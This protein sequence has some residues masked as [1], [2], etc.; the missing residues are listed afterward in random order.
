[1]KRFWQDASEA[2]CD[3]HSRGGFCCAIILKNE[4]YSIVISVS[5]CSKQHTCARLETGSSMH[6]DTLGHS[7]RAIQHFFSNFLFLK[8]MSVHKVSRSSSHRHALL[9]D[10]MNSLRNCGSQ[11]TRSTETPRSRSN[12]IQ[13]SMTWIS[14]PSPIRDFGK[15]LDRVRTHAASAAA[16]SPAARQLLVGTFL[17]FDKWSPARCP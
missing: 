15:L 8:R 16:R 9:A 17:A 12:I 10:S 2:N 4:E 6:G 14:G 11:T 13:Q 1:M 5:H 7:T 3:C